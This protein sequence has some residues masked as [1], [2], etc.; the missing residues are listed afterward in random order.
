MTDNASVESTL[1][2]T[3][4][5]TSLREGGSSLR[6][7]TAEEV[8][9]LTTDLPVVSE[10]ARKLIILL[11]NAETSNEEVIKTLRCDNVLTA[12]LLRLCNSAQMGLESPV[13]SIDQAVLLAGTDAVY[14]MACTI[15]FG[16]PMGFTEPGQAVETNGLWTHSL[17][18]ALGA[19]YLTTTEP[20]QSFPQSVAF[21]AGLLHDIGKLALSRN[22]IPRTRTEIREVMIKKSLSRFAAEK[23]ILGTDHA[24]VG[25]CLLQ[26]WALPEVI[27]EATAH[28]H[29]PIVQPAAQLSAVVY[30]SNCAAH[31]TGTSTGPGWD[32]Y[33]VQANQTA[34]LLLGLPVEICAQMITKAQ[35]A[36]K[37]VNQFLNVV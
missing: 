32:A 34:A 5:A 15:G 1:R 3:V 23:E 29:A 33:A 27:V 30:L 4:S 8:V 6:H 31:L 18:V 36:M 25:A 12:K 13:A 24:E 17:S 19:E 37:G 26:R 28:H 7:I 10:T 35:D 22:L 11:N 16:D 14:R 2:T 20:Y 21:T 9:A